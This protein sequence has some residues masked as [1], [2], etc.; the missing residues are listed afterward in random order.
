MFNRS[1]VFIVLP[2]V[3]SF[4]LVRVFN[5]FLSIPF[6]HCSVLSV[7]PVPPSCNHA[8]PG[9]QEGFNITNEHRR[10]REHVDGDSLLDLRSNYH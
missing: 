6:L 1:S 10:V 2:N 3:R 4:V 7:P 5:V 9:P 8:V